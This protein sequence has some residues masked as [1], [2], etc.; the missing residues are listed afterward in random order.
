MGEGKEADEEGRMNELNVEVQPGHQA[1]RMDS[2][3][4]VLICIRNKLRGRR[5]EK[6]EGREADEEGRMNEFSLEVQPGLQANRMD[7]NAKV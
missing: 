6:G 1:N 2:E 3:T 4:K 7:S 5:Q